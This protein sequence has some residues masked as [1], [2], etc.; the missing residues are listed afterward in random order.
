[1]S[2]CL[3][4]K[5]FII[6]GYFG[7]QYMCVY[8][9]TYQVYVDLYE[10]RYWDKYY[11]SKMRLTSHGRRV[12][13]CVIICSHNKSHVRILQN[14]EKFNWEFRMFQVIEEGPGKGWK[15]PKWP[16]RR[17][18]RPLRVLDQSWMDLGFILCNEGVT[19]EWRKSHVTHKY[20]C[21]P[22]FGE[23]CIARW[24]HNQ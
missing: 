6:E 17:G 21:H 16:W 5:I 13:L 7:P 12:S 3:W 24:S 9:S 22:G 4:G 18:E 1:M 10:R 23:R 15:V 20:I 2:I 11:L 8:S 19:V 14:W